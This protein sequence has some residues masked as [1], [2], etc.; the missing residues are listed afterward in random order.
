MEARDPIKSPAYNLW[1]VNN[2][3]QRRLRTLLEPFGLTHAQFMVLASIEKIA[4]KQET[5]SQAAVS[6][7]CDMDEN[8]V[9]QVIKTLELAGRIHRTC[10][11]EDKRARNLELSAAGL[12]LLDSVRQILYPAMDSFFEC[13]GDEKQAFNSMLRQ[14]LSESEK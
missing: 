6:R 12:A 4:A 11:V 8:M 7:F 1:L 3:W 2:A 10:S 5:S 14:L 13:L 9:S